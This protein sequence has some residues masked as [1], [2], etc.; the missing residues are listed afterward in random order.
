MDGRTDRQ[1]DGR[2]IAYTRYSIY[3]VAR[4]KYGSSYIRLPDVASQ[5]CEIPQNSPK[6]EPIAVQGHAR[7]SILVPIESAYAT[8]C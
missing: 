6:I 2:T 5:I 8:S 3:A 7:S 1:M 4:K